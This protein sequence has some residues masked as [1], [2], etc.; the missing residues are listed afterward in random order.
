MKHNLINTAI[1]EHDIARGF[2]NAENELEKAEGGTRRYSLIK[3]SEKHSAIGIYDE[4][5]VVIGYLN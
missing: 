5:D 2:A 1:W 4:N 3:V